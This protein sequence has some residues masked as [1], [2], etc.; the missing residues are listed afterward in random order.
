MKIDARGMMSWNEMCMGSMCMP[1]CVHFQ[2]MLSA[3]GEM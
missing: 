2:K 3:D 1:F